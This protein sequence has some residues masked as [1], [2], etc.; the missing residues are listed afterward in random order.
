MFTKEE[1]KEILRVLNLEEDVDS[2]TFEIQR[3][4]RSKI[5]QHLMRANYTESTVGGF[6]TK[7]K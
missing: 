6:I 3:S 2:N 1:A 5:E 4:I 7:I